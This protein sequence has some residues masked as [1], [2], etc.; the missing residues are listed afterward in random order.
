MA[1]LLALPACTGNLTGGGEGKPDAGLGTNGGSGGTTTP[2]AGSGGVAPDIDKLDCSKHVIDP[3]PSPMQLLSRRQYLN[4]VKELA[5]DVAGV[6]QALGDEV[7]ASA[8]GLV[9]PDVTQVHLEHFQKAAATIAAAI[10]GNQ[11]SLDKLAPCASGTAPADCAKSVVQK[12]G[13]LAYRA[14]VTDAADIDR[15]VQLF[16]VGAATSYAHGIELLL[17]GMLQSPRFLYRVEIGT[18]EKVSDS[19]VKLSGSEL[20]ARLSYALWDSPPNDK[21]NQAVAAGELGTK[22]GVGAQLAW[23]LQD[24][25]GQ[26]LVNRFLENWMHVGAVDGLVKNAELYPE[27]STGTLRSSLRGQA[28]AFFDDLLTRQG[29]KLNALFTSTSVFYNKDLGSYYG[30]T[31]GDTFQSLEK[32]D[33]TAAGVLTLPALLA[34]TGKPNESSPIYRGRF[35]REALLCQQLPSPPANI[36]APPE[37]MP[38]VSTRERAAQHEVDPSCSGCHQL[39]DPI[40]FG[41]E[42]FDT[43]GRYRTEDG[44]KTVDA[45]G[46]VIAT[47]D[48]DGAFNGVAELGKK[49]AASSEV[50]ECVTR[51]WFRYA[52]NRFEQPLDGCTMQSVLESFDAAGQDLNSL[53][54]AIVKTDAFL[55]RRPIDAQA[56]AQV[57][58]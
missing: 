26:K 20:A 42:N 36:P 29:G 19:A 10:V 45:S 13:A 31:G 23:M 3:G 48:I 4:T 41:F 38:G 8:F 11:A 43:I 34:V 50:K 25:R 49:L 17:Q 40:G 27:F 32:T 2:G 51:Q 22:E 58:Q 57:M 6:E 35:V 14:P 47:R 24:V 37:V 30:V 7:D 16:N 53:P 39:L 56:P 33:G 5:G 18:G 52:I 44:G 9:Q 15:H 12:F 28:S 55:Y 54:Q 1:T 46:N 21:L